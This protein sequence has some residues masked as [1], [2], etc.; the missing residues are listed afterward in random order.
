M[1]AECTRQASMRVFARARFG[2][3]EDTVSALCIG[4]REGPA[5]EAQVRT[6]SVREDGAHLYRCGFE[7]H[8]GIVGCRDCR[9]DQDAPFG[10]GEVCLSQGIGEMDKRKRVGEP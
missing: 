6:D 4:E 2:L 1:F 5:V 8:S 7:Q 10:G 3:L 9:T